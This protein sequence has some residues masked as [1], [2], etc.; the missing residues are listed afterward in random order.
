VRAEIENAL[1]QEVVTQTIE[2]LTSSADVTRT[3][4][5]EVDTSVLSNL[6]LLED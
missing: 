6:D 5:E 3:G 4:P 1:S 2:D